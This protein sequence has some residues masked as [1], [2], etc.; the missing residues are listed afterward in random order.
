[1]AADMQVVAQVSIDDSNVDKDVQKTEGK[2][3]SAFGKI[4]TGAKVA[5]AAFTAIGTAAVAVGTKAVTSA[6]S[7]DSQ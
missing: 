7:L 4:G 5:T 6:V 3:S 1:M 2:I